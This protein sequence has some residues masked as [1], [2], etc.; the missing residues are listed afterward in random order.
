[1]IKISRAKNSNRFI[2]F[3]LAVLLILTTFTPNFTYASEFGL[4]E[5]DSDVNNTAPEIPVFDTN[6]NSEPVEYKVG[7]V[8]NALEVLAKVTTGGTITYQWCENS[9]KSIEG[10]TEISSATSTSYIPLTDKKGEKY[11][12]AVATNTVNSKISTSTS[13]IAKV[14]V[15]EAGGWDGTTTTKP[16]ETEINESTYYQINNAEEL[17][18][19]AEHVNSSDG[20]DGKN[21]VNAIL[22]GDIDLNSKE[23]TPIGTKDYLGDFNGNGYKLLNLKVSS[24]GLFSIN[25]GTIRNLTI[26]S[27]TLNSTI[28]NFGSFA[29]ENKGFILN[30]KNQANV[31]SSSTNVGGLV[32]MNRGTI[33]NSINNGVV[34]SES[35]AK[36][37]YASGI[38]GR[39]LGKVIKCYNTGAIISTENKVR[40]AGISIG[41]SIINCYN[42]GKIESSQSTNNY[43]VANNSTDCYYLD[44]SGSDAVATAM[45]EEQMKNIN[46]VT[47]L[48]NG[49][50]DDISN[51]NNGYPILSWQSTGAYPEPET[52]DGL[53]VNSV[54]EARNGS[55]TV[56]INKLF[57]YTTLLPTN[58]TGAVKIGDGEASPVT[59]TKIS[60]SGTTVILSFKELDR[61][62]IDQ[63]AVISVSGNGTEAKTKEFTLYASGDWLAYAEA[64][65]IVQEGDADYQDY[66]GYYKISSG[67]ELAW[68]AGLVDGTL[69]DGTAKNASANAV[70]TNDISLN[71]TTNWKTWNE[72]TEGLRYWTPI[73]TKSLY[74]GIFN[75]NNHQISGMYIINTDLDLD[76]VGLFGRMRAKISNVGLV[77][78]YIYCNRTSSKTTYYIGGICGQA[79]DSIE[80]CYSVATIYVENNKSSSSVGGIAGYSNKE[81][82]NCYNLGKIEVHGAINYGAHVGGINGFG[83][84]SSIT[85]CYNTGAISGFGPKDEVGGIRGYNRDST[86]SNC[87]NTGNV[88]GFKDKTSGIC[89]YGCTNCYYIDDIPKSEHEQGIEKDKTSFKDGTVLGL[90]GETF[91]AD[92]NK[93]NG[94]PIL[95]SHGNKTITNNLPTLKEGIISGRTLKM[96][97]GK[98]YSIDISTI[99]TDEDGD[100]LT[101]YVRKDNDTMFT[102][103]SSKDYSYEYT[104]EDSLTL[105]FFADDIYSFGEKYE[106]TL[107]APNEDDL[108][109]LRESISTAETLNTDEYWTKND[110]WDGKQWNVKNTYL[111]DENEGFWNSMQIALSEAK[112]VVE[113][114]DDCFKED[115][116]KAKTKLDDTISMLMPRSL[117]N[118]TLIYEI[119][120]KEDRTNREESDY[121]TSKWSDYV[122]NMEKGRNMLKS[123]YYNADDTLP[124]GKKIG[125]PKDINKGEYQIT[126]NECANALMYAVDSLINQKDYDK[127]IDAQ[128]STVALSMFVDANIKQSNYTEESWT[129]FKTARSNADGF[130]ATLDKTSAEKLEEMVRLYSVYH[131]ALVY[132]LED[133][134]GK[135]TITFAVD[136]S[137]VPTPAYFSEMTIDLSSFSK[138]DFSQ[139]SNVKYDEMLTKTPTVLHAIV[140]MWNSLGITQMPISNTN[141]GGYVY[142][143]LGNEALIIKMFPNDQSDYS[144]QYYT[145]Y[146]D[147][148]KM[149]STDAY[150]VLHDGAVVT[151]SKTKCPG[152][153]NY[154]GS[155]T[156]MS[157]DVF[158]RDFLFLRYKDY[159]IGDEVYITAGE[160]FNLTV[161]GTNPLISYYT[162][163]YKGIEDM[164]IYLSKYDP[165]TGKVSIAESMNT[166]SL[167]DG[168]CSI[169]FDHEGLYIV[170]AYD[171]RNL[172]Y[173][174][175]DLGLRGYDGVLNIAPYIVVNV[176]SPDAEELIA[177]K[178][179][180]INELDNAYSIENEMDFKPED[181]ETFTNAY[182]DGLIAIEAAITYGTAIDA[183]NDALNVM[184]AVK[185]LNHDN[186]MSNLRTLLSYV[187]GLDETWSK[188]NSE[189]NSIKQ[190]Y[191]AY[192]ALNEYQK[193]LLTG[194]EQQ[195]VDK[196]L[197]VY[198]TDG[199]TMP[200][201]REY[202]LKIN[203]V[204]ETGG[205][206]REFK[207]QTAEETTDI[208][209]ENGIANIKQGDVVSLS[210]ILSQNFNDK[211]AVFEIDGEKTVL[212]KWDLQNEK[213]LFSI[214]KTGISSI[215]EDEYYTYCNFTM[216]GKNTVLTVCFVADEEIDPLKTEH[217]E[218]VNAIITAFSSYEKNN[219]S[220]DGW[221]AIVNAKNIGLE[222]VIAS[223]TID[224][225]N[226]AKEN[227][228]V[229][230][231]NVKVKIIEGNIPNFGDVVGSVDVYVENTTY[232]GGDFTGSIVSELNF[233]I[234][235][236]DTIMTIVLRAL[237]LKGYSWT[238]TGGTEISGIDDYG[239]AYLA[240]ITKNGK[241]LGEFSGS[242]GSGW[243]VTLNDF[244]INEGMQQFSVKNAK[245]SDG[246]EICIMFTQNLGEDLGGTWGNSDTTLKELNLSAG[247]LYPSFSSSINNYTLVLSSSDNKLKVTPTA[248]NRNYLVKTFLNDKVTTKTEGVSFYKRTRYIP[249]RSGDFV[250]IGVGEYA[251]PSMNNQLTEARN[252]SGTW[253]KLN[254]ITP[255]N[256]ASHVMSLIDAL[257]STKIIKLSQV[258]TIKSIRDVFE[259]LSSSEKLK[260]TNIQKLTDTEN[261][262]D[263]LQEIEV[264]KALLKKIPNASK[265]TLSDK[266]TVMSADAAYKKLMDEQK[267]YITVGDV[268]NYN[269][270]IDKLTELGAFKSGG[271]PTKI[272]GNIEAP[273]IEGITVEIKA[274]TKIVNGVANSK[275]NTQQIKDMLTEIKGSDV[276]GITIT[277]NT[278]KKI[279]KSSVEIP[280]TSI[281]EISNGK[282]YLNIQTFKHSNFNW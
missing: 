120:I 16:K 24:K 138:N 190:V 29:G 261:R 130:A 119:I 231:A 208:I 178:Q 143:Y 183:K 97:I 10:A 270:A 9:K 267:L 94:Y 129:I 50:M 131:D 47:A 139:F 49:Y 15:N 89:Y 279:L 113:N 85:N 82:T 205:V 251:W 234:A 86:I 269:D 141:D 207:N 34:S 30:C 256:G 258:D 159:K 23:W 27:G 80:N 4:D 213:L 193:G 42:T 110:R 104:G 28:A 96:G 216:P 177:A 61:G 87:Y 260:V 211:S 81:I 253:Y 161:E 262:I 244:F 114:S 163:I 133:A 156:P 150:S 185:R 63:T 242:A 223:K 26:A 219:Y 189:I 263:F 230:M 64:P 157:T 46:F 235:E 31:T 173:D 74:E 149:D 191:D 200:E 117:V 174:N 210:Y 92:H 51:L 11:Y 38:A 99:F 243:M 146:I 88:I 66:V 165:E 240:S 36:N 239:I 199:N 100:N 217:D 71:D 220:T 37:V 107:T 69:K 59:F 237:A 54:D 93:N 13:I 60:Q 22:N 122:A 57:E 181:Y 123:L 127:A 160:T 73:G 224:A 238:G 52:I 90:L 116:E 166:V 170:S 118:A 19:F 151:L 79:L 102:K 53:K 212:R 209:I 25:S 84:D 105:T 72:K 140:N 274:E 196:V 172:F 273:I 180:I 106:V 58:F 204:P 226:L 91:T 98:T 169:N 265:V 176:V 247:K 95:V 136:S 152:Y 203:L 175:L 186:I 45:T 55:V 266:A 153:K 77:D 3:F 103:L 134:D 145:V 179:L 221:I 225:I 282:L 281:A 112:E 67:V 12:Y 259:L 108:N 56:T 33:I 182:H 233:D 257:P 48:G 252:Y 268:K 17:A 227:A 241:S 249:V 135:V 7:D 167:A 144:E 8:A 2:S 126:V 246:D 78:S 184:K 250:N 192:N 197:E 109:S 168:L 276:S 32:G 232:L 277:A 275:V 65:S 188:A 132:D 245:I 101:Y 215:S 70:L 228:I 76:Q 171:K 41:G 195:I 128:K 43:A 164:G 201:A 142:T 62:K 68:F 148:L 111:V 18:W 115:I 278:D 202:T 158:G 162:G 255:D 272:Q 137:N 254:I 271:T 280:K 1:V 229:A 121:S 222:E 206:F 198:K 75:G 35:I 44:T 39:T 218:A 125:D 194:I 40:I 5:Q 236:N 83:L 14:I 147:G 21:K 214:D 6:L 187:P 124:D 248:A 264:V 154:S 20:A 155:E